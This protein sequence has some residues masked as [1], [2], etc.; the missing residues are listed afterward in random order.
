MVIDL[1]FGSLQ[2]IVIELE[3]LSFCAHQGFG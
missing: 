1:T 3:K 2:I